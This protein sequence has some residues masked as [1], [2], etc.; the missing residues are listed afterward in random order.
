MKILSIRIAK[1]T[2]ADA[3]TKV[4]AGGHYNRIKFHIEVRKFVRNWLRFIKSYQSDL[5]QKIIQIINI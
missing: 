1:D 3:V 2:E 4:K 5:E